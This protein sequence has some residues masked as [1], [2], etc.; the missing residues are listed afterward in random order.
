MLVLRAALLPV[1]PVTRQSCAA[2]G[3]TR[4]PTSEHIWLDTGRSRQL[5][6]PTPEPSEIRQMGRVEHWRQGTLP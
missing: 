5:H 2:F 1:V 6:W 4:S 3:L